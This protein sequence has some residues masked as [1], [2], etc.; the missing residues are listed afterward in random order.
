[1][2]VMPVPGQ[3]ITKEVVFLLQAQ[4]CRLI[5]GYDTCNTAAIGHQ[6]PLFSSL[7][8]KPRKGYISAL[9]PPRRT[10]LRLHYIRLDTRSLILAH[11]PVTLL[12]QRSQPA[13]WSPTDR[14]HAI[15][16]P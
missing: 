4:G 12:K 16:D 6:A 11:L 8:W 15:T 14:H 10:E 2:T 13:M 3:G 9:H 1:M 5:K 7:Y